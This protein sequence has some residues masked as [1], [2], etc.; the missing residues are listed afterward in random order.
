M[1]ISKYSILFIFLTLLIL[2]SPLASGNNTE[3]LSDKG[4]SISEQ[5]Q[6]G[7]EFSIFITISNPYDA[8]ITGNL[9]LIVPAYFE[10]QS[11]PTIPINLGPH[12][13]QTYSFIARPTLIRNNLLSVD[14]FKTFAVGASPGKHKLYFNINYGYNGTI[15]SDTYPFEILVVSSY[16]SL[17]PACIIGGLLGSILKILT[18]ENDLKK[19]ISSGISGWRPLLWGFIGAVLAILIQP[20][21][22][23]YNFQGAIL[24]GTTIGYLGSSVIEDILKR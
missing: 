17:L 1:S 19:L 13:S 22:E 18:K 9:S 8:I 24:L 14:F 3:L 20:F 2:L 5:I 16:L 23:I 12:S 10:I 21:G 6:K 7:R 4:I 11:S 15:Q